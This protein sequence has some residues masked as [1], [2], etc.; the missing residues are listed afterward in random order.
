MLNNLY[1]NYRL[2]KQELARGYTAKDMEFAAERLVQDYKSYTGWRVSSGPEKTFVNLKLQDRALSAMLLKDP[3][4]LKIRDEVRGTVQAKLDKHL[5]FPDAFDGPSVLGGTDAEH[6]VDRGK[7]LN[8]YDKYHVKAGLNILFDG[9]GMPV[10]DWVSTL[11]P[12]ATPTTEERAEMKQMARDMVDTSGR[13][14]N[15][16]KFNHYKIQTFGTG[17]GHSRANFF[18]QVG[19]KNI[20]LKGVLRKPLLKH[21]H[22]MLYIYIYI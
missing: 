4:L 15:A 3:A 19:N 21:N 6:M 1:L 5:H 9:R 22:C 8:Q 13:V 20:K 11:V 10:V 16:A 14:F 17:R 18:V 7:K 2:P 12:G